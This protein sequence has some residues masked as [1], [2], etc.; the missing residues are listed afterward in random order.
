[1]A[2][3]NSK[4]VKTL[5]RIFDAGFSS[6]KEIQSMTVAEMLSI[7][8]V[9]VQDIALIND[10]QRAIKEHCVLDFLA[11]ARDFSKADKKK[12]VAESKKNSKEPDER[13]DHYDEGI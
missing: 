12:S 10:L 2:Q 7:E 13:E 11:G 1:M 6:E 9:T 8:G 4:T 3:I 5:N